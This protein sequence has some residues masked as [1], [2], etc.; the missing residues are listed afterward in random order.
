M[1]KIPEQPGLAGPLAERTDVAAGLEP[2]PLRFPTT[3]RKTW[4]GSEVQAWLDELPPLVALPFVAPHGR[5]T[6]EPLAVPLEGSDSI[7][8]GETP[9]SKRPPLQA[10]RL[11]HFSH[12]CR[13][14]CM[15]VWVP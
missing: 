15:P 7:A 6:S 12:A 2:Y 11:R 13:R 14:G 3:L 9:A 10:M 5:P 8:S 4:S 1:N